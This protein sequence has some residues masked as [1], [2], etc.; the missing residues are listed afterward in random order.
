MVLTAIRR[1]FRSAKPGVSRATRGYQP[2][3]L[4]D[5]G[6]EWI[7]EWAHPHGVAYGS[8]PDSKNVPEWVMKAFLNGNT[9]TLKGGVYEWIEGIYAHLKGPTYEYLIVHPQ[10]EFYAEFYRRKRT[11]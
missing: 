6:W 11:P 3:I 4:Q 5:A 1:L 2:P 7:G 10:D 9:R 8:P